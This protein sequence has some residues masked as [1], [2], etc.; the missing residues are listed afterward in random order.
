MTPR[1]HPRSS[2]GTT[3][4]VGRRDDAV[5]DDLL[6][7]RLSVRRFHAVRERG[8]ERDE[9]DADHRAAAVAAVRLGFAPRSSLASRSPGGQPYQRREWSNETRREHRDADE[10]GARLPQ[11]Q[12]SV[13]CP[14]VVD[15]HRASEQSERSD[16]DEACDPQNV[17]RESRLRLRPSRTAAMGGT[18]VARSPGRAPLRGDATPTISA[19]TTVRSANTR[20]VLGSS[21][22]KNRK[23][24]WI[25]PPAADPTQDR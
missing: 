5:G 18:R 19:T 25:P 12:Q 10:E 7:D 21:K 22:S 16:D 13:R 17:R 3:V 11:R 20:S 2:P 24:A 4:P 8:D 9:C 6:L 14:H 23:S 15:E 1:G